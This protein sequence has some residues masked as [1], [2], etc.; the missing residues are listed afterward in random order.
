MSKLDE[1]IK[2]AIDAHSGQVRKITFNPYILHPLEV[3]AIAGTLTRDEDILCAAV[4]HDVVEDTEGTINE[5][6]EK[7]GNR[8]AELVSSETEDKHR[9][10][11]PDVTWKRRKEESLAHLRASEDIG[12]KVIWISDKL[13]NVR[14]FYDAYVKM[15][16]ALWNS[17]NQKDKNEQ[18]W[19]YREVYKIVKPYF[20]DTLMFKEYEGLIQV[21]FGK[22][23]IDEIWK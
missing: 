10:L 12:A 21:L 4:L 11:P 9:E 1:A 13:S 16:D 23:I 22:E 15:G 17:F 18:K 19:Y 8:V 5:I 14:S 6:R 7:F 2:F 3:V 20:A